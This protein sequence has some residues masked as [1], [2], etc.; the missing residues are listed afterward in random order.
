MI[1]GDREVGRWNGWDIVWEMIDKGKLICPSR[2]D[3]W[4]HKGKRG[5]VQEGPRD[6][7]H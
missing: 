1:S 7:N 2:M 3:D 4:M 6:M 5:H